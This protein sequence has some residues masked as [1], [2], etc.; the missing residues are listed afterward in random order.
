M[1]LGT[2]R[3]P[4]G[5]A[6]CRKIALQQIKAGS[7]SVA[8]A[9]PGC[10]LGVLQA[11][12]GGSAWAIGLGTER[13]FRGR[14]L[15]TSVVERV[16]VAVDETIADFVDGHFRGGADTV[17]TVENGGISVAAVSTRAPATLN[18]R[19]ASIA[20]AIGAGKVKPPSR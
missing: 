7:D 20:A 15:L 9:T 10:A 2:T 5:A 1:H 13:P 4:A 3:P 12:G 19:L 16:D 11:A 18:A 14:Q 8:A 17:F 6:A